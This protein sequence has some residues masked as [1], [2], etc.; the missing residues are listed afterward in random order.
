MQIHAK[1]EFS[2]AT[3]M[4]IVILQMPILYNYMPLFLKNAPKQFAHKGKNLRMRLIWQGA[5]CVEMLIPPGVRNQSKC[6]AALQ[7]A[8][9]N[10]NVYTWSR[11]YSAHCKK[12]C[13]CFNLAWFPQLQCI[14]AINDS[15]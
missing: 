11:T 3:C 6:R 2:D 1:A 14:I 5:S 12:M 7:E 8:L 4:C 13:S 9:L 15:L 10:M